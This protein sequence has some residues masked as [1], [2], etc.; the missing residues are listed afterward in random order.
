MILCLTYYLRF[1]RYLMTTNKPITVI[2]NGKGVEDCLGRR[3]TLLAEITVY[4][5]QEEKN[6][7]ET[8]AEQAQQKP[9]LQSDNFRKEIIDR[10]RFDRD[11]VTEVG[12]L[13]REMESGPESWKK[14]RLAKLETTIEVK[15]VI[16]EKTVSFWERIEKLA[17]LQRAIVL[18]EVLGPPKGLQQNDL[19]GGNDVCNCCVC[20]C[21]RGS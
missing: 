8:Y 2:M 15:T 1:L 10:D 18:S 12:R 13:E 21:E 19:K 14:E 7:V 3:S 4:F 6:K 16:E 9:V 5:T 17:P 11:K 20:S